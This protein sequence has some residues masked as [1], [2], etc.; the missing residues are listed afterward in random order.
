MAGNPTSSIGL[1]GLYLTWAIPKLDCSGMFFRALFLVEIIDEATNW[2]FE[3]ISR[4]F[5]FLETKTTM[6]CQQTLI[7]IGMVVHSDPVAHF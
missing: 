3:T 6:L 7:N 1:Y 2:L 4:I 5:F